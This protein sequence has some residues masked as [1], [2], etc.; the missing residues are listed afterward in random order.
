MTF[1]S[2]KIRVQGDSQTMW[3]LFHTKTK[4]K[5]LSLYSFWSLSCVRMPVHVCTCISMHTHTHVCMR[6][7][8]V[9]SSLSFPKIVL[10][11][12]KISYIFH[13]YFLKSIFTRLGSKPALGL[14]VLPLLENGGPCHK[15]FKML[16]L[17]P[18]NLIV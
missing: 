8:R 18:L 14:K 17:V 9:S 13:K 16:G 4:C 15:G 7:L 1:Y 12:L 10:F 5:K 2:G 6:T 11:L 3:D